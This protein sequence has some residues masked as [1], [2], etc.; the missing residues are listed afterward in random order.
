MMRPEANDPRKRTTQDG[1]AAQ[2]RMVRE[3]LASSKVVLTPRSH[4]PEPGR[5]LGSFVR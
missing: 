1:Q 3:I 2:Q 4:R 5:S